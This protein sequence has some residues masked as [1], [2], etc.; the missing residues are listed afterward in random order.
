MRNVCDTV[1]PFVLRNDTM[2]VRD[3][4]QFVWER[5]HASNESNVR[6]SNVCTS[7]ACARK[8][9]VNIVCKQSRCVN[10]VNMCN[11]D[12]NNVR[13]VC[14]TAIPFVFEQ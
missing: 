10:S 1:M 12:T 4:M 6:T 2:C 9:R 7:K 8:A 3:M 14:D 5:A 11:I 13:K